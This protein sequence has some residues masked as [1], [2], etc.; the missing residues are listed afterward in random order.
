MAKRKP[1]EAI[2]HDYATGLREIDAANEGLCFLLDR[3]F[4]DPLTECRRVNGT[5]DHS[6]CSKIAAILS[7]VDRNFIAQ[8]RLMD[9]GAYPLADD[10]LRDHA[11]LVSG[12]KSM[13]AARICADD[14]GPKVRAFIAGWTARHVHGCDRALGAWVSRQG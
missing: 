13:Q 10:H 3:I 12:L 2:G 5:C 6:R 8:E 4:A 14:D 7:Y 9:E 11:A 1:R